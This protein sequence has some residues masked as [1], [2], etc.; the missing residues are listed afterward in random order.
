VGGWCGRTTRLLCEAAAGLSEM[1][2]L[3]LSFYRLMLAD[4]ERLALAPRITHL[5]L[6]NNNIGPEGMRAV[7]AGLPGLTYLNVGD[8]RLHDEGVAHLAGLTRLVGLVASFNEASDA[9]MG[10][11]LTP[12]TGLTSLSSAWNAV[13]ARTGVAIERMRGLRELDLS[14]TVA[15]ALTARLAGLSAL[16]ALELNYCNL[17]D[18]D[19]APL[20]GLAAL[21]HLSLSVNNLSSAGVVRLAPRLT[22]LTTLDLSWNFA[23]YRA[24][25]AIADHLPALVKLNLRRNAI[26]DAGAH[27]LASLAALLLL[28]ISQNGLSSPTRSLLRAELTRPGRKLYL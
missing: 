3:R 2:D 19:A 18:G 6:F 4:A 24:A 7:A 25:L 13:G 14:F 10:A 11:A 22:R 27:A 12:L 23:G 1:E 17:S 5:D 21:T 8:N 26:T 15:P 9:A 28:D 20:G 16:V